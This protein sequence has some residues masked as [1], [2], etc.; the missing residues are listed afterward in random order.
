MIAQIEIDRDEMNNILNGLERTV[1]I[2]DET[3]ED[4]NLVSLSESN[5][6]KIYMRHFD[7]YQVVHTLS[8]SNQISIDVDEDI[9]MVFSPDVLTS[10]VRESNSDKIKIRLSED[11]FS[12]EARESWFSTPT[13]F[14]LNLF[15]ESQFQPITTVP[16]FEYITSIN[17]KEMVENLK[18]M[19]TVSKVVQLKLVDAEFW[20]SVSD[21]VHG[22]GKV[23]ENIDSS[24][25]EIDS[26]ESK[27]RTDVIQTFL[28]SVDTELV[29]I[30]L[31]DDGNLRIRA[32][33]EGHEAELTLA[34]R[35][36]D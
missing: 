3:F 11:Q 30:L 18:M 12:V 16:G 9:E 31:K 22:S 26:F 4:L 32:E 36:A 20:I 19:S 34:P 5:S 35:I 6:L 2:D 29:D 15:H 17:R 24:Q 14:T 8:D 10:L 13:T 21:A 1:S 28:N 23:M 27:Y 7:L 25:T 33:K